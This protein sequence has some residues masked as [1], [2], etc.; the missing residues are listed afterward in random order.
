MAR[1]KL[2]F[3][4]ATAWALALTAQGANAASLNPAAEAL[5]ES[6]AG[7]RLMLETHGCHHS[8]ECGPP[9]GFGCEQFNHRHLHMLCMPVRCDRSAGCDRTPSEGVCRHIAPR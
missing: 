3:S 5:K 1:T 8:C 7:S 2:A 6:A 4:V 9:K